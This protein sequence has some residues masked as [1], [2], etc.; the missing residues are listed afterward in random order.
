MSIKQ[1]NQFLVEKIIEWFEKN[2]KIGYRYSFYSDDNDYIKELLRQ[3]YCEE[4]NYILYRETQLPYIEINNIKLVFL[5]DVE[6]E[7]NQNFISTIRDAVSKPEK[8][9]INSALFILHRS[10]LDTLINSTYNLTD[11]DNSPWNIFCLKDILMPLCNGNIVFETLLNYQSKIIKEEE[12]SVFGYKFIYESIIKQELQFNQLGLFPDNELLERK[13]KKDIENR[14][15]INQNLYETVEYNITNFLDD[16]ENRLKEFS[17]KFIKDN[18]K[19]E[20]WQNVAF[21]DILRDIEKNKDKSQNISFEKLLIDEKYF[22]RDQSSTTRGKRNKNIII[23]AKEEIFDLKLKFKG[24]GIDKK[25]FQIKENNDIKQL[26]FEYKNR[27]F[28]I[29]LMVQQQP[30]YFRIKLA[31]TKSTE[32]YSFNIL[33]LRE[34]WFNLDCIKNI[35]LISPKKKEISLQ[36]DNYIF[37]FSSNNI[38]PIVIE[39]ETIID[40]KQNPSIDIT[41]YYIKSENI[42]KFSILNKDKKLNFIIEDKPN[43]K[44][45]SFL[46]LIYNTQLENIL[47]NQNDSQYIP[48]KN[49][50]IVNNRESN[51]S[52]I[53]KLLIEYEHKFIAQNIFRDKNKDDSINK[54]IEIDSNLGVAFQAFL[55]YFYNKKTTP[56]IASWN[57]KLFNLAKEYINAYLEF[58]ENIKNY[59]TLDEN[60]KKVFEIGFVY[61]N[62]KKYLS[63]FSPLVLSHIIYVLQNIKNDDSFYNIARIT[64]KRFNSKGLFPY[65]FISDDE[66]NYTKVIEENPFWLIFENRNESDLNYISK[67]V[68]EKIDEFTNS[69]KNLFKYRKEAP[70]LINSINNGLNRELFNGIIQYYIKNYKNPLNIVVAI[71][72]TNNNETSFDTFSD[73]QNY[74]EISQ[75]YNI[76]KDKEIIIDIIRKHLTYSKYLDIHNQKY[77]HL[78]FYKN[79]QKIKL[80]NKKVFD[81]KSGLVVNGIISGESSEKIDNVYYSGFGL[82]NI[83][84]NN[85]QH[86]RVAKIYNSMQKAVYKDMESYDKESVL[87]LGINK[88]FDALEKSYESSIWTTIIDPKVTLEFFMNKKELL[89]I[90][91]SDQ[92][93]NSADYDAI[94]VTKKIDLYEKIVGGTKIISEFNAFNG[95]WLL[96]MFNINDKI[97]RERKSI[98]S[99]YKY[100]TAF[101]STEDITWIP[102]S[103]AEMIRVSGGTGLAMSQSDFSRYNQNIQKGA[104]S[105][106][107]LLIGLKGN[108]IIL[109]P[110]EVKAGSADLN[111]AKNQVKALKDYFY[112]ILFP[113]NSIKSKLLKGL[114]IRQLFMHIEKYEIYEVF[115][116]DY[117]KKIY[118]QREELLKGEYQLIEL[119]EYSVGAIITFLDNQ[120][121][122]QFSIDD[123]ILECKLSWDYVDKMIKTSY[124]TIK[125]E[126]F[127]KKYETDINYLLDKKIN[128]KEESVKKIENNI[129]SSNEYAINIKFGRD[130]KDN[131]D[132]LWYPTDTTKTFNTNTGIIGTMGTG[133]TQF[134]KSIITQLLD[135]SSIGILIFD[136][137]GDYIKED[138]QQRTNAK[139][140]EP[141]HLPFNPL[142]LFGDK[143][144]LPIHTANLF[145]TTLS[146]AFNLGVK[147]QSKLNKLILEAYIKKGI[148]KQDK[149]SW[150]KLAPTINDIWDIYNEEEIT[151]D[152]LYASLEKLISFEIFEPN[153]SKVTSLYDFIDGATVI[154]LSGYDS[155]IQNLIVAI[156]LDIFYTQMHTKGSST[157]SGNYREM[158][159][160][161]LVDEADN[162]MSQNFE[163]LKKI[164]KEGREFGVGIILSTQELTHFKTSEDNYANYIF[165]WVVHKVSNI[166]EQDIQSIFNISNKN[167]AKHLMSQIRELQKHYSLYVEG[168]KKDVLK[169]KDLAFWELLKISKD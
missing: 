49:S 25:E 113:D 80:T 127:N 134:T 149:K 9:F 143:P 147:Q 12:Q 158:T 7:L 70:L 150:K 166:K 98:I 87:S 97:K 10:R 41:E 46:P 69:F 67:L 11:I 153:S 105:D 162:F 94:T 54:L 51:L 101:L 58:M 74:E 23:F 77:C 120:F 40:I 35:F 148:Q 151:Q 92:Y 169:M 109:Y 164:L 33:V 37:N 126:I 79:N 86:L 57:E 93:S 44:S 84:I 168:N 32:Q 29:Q 36:T 13:N 71:Y 38:T 104:I 132:I 22:I 2:I 161:I 137:K 119:E 62:E 128:K 16:L 114:F 24:K 88:D 110:V 55:E 111:K 123:K 43:E 65:L 139:I 73:M 124:L 112:T 28:S 8:E 99:A 144:L 64:I 18:F 19:E 145:K 47:F 85:Y 14:I 60:I 68:Y 133:K 103:L 42:V 1:F 136:Y 152:S 138:F 30:I 157:I 95:K 39:N 96:E 131:S 156:T 59:K 78:A 89:L 116:K 48:S 121:S 129:K 165:S 3:L 75:K 61:K 15:K 125:D 91:Y 155:D 45:I 167:E 21:E 76:K 66:Y 5:N 141:Y 17:P 52:S 163:S 130:I 72:D 63:P 56:S 34:E 115:E 146:K 100:I 102:I 159:K 122:S 82:R 140:L 4:V 154:N 26:N 106:D 83:E 107:I 142:S 50:I 81:R 117:F 53:I 20:S 90:H 27:I 108:D 135:N 6:K 118:S 31:R 160:M